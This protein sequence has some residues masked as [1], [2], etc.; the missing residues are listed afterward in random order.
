PNMA[1][2]I[3]ITVIATGF[4]RSS[5]PRR[6][7]ERQPRLDVRRAQPASYM[8]TNESVSVHADVQSGEAKHTGA[9]LS[10]ANKDD[11]DIPT[12]LR[13]RR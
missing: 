6:A 1:D 8:R 3:R 11:L 10:A 2:D 13:N 12:F 5:M 4:D 7:L 9:S